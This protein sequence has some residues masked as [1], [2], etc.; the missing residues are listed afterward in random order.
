[1]ETKKTRRFIR[2]DYRVNG[3]YG[4]F[5]PP[6]P[7]D[8]AKQLGWQEGETYEWQIDKKRQS[9]VLKRIQ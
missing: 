4:Y 8:F 6:V 7:M 1:M 9:L 3:G 5:R 2:R